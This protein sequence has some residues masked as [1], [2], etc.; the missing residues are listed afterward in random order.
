MEIPVINR[1]HQSFV[2]FALVSPLITTEH[3][4]RA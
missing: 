2:S 3:C 1:E 4:N